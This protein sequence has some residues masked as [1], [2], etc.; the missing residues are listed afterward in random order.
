MPNLLD[1]IRNSKLSWLVF[2]QLRKIWVRVVGFAVFAL[3]TAGLSQLAGPLVPARMVDRLGSDAVD[4]VLSILASS[5][6]AVTTFSLSI[7]VSAFASAAQS[8]TPRATALLQEDRTTQNVL[9]TFLGAFLF[10]LVGIV[11]LKAGYYSDAGRVVLFVA[12]ILTIALVVV[13]LIRWISHLT[14]FGRMHDTLERVEEAASRAIDR[15]LKTPWLGGRPQTAP[16]PETGTPVFAQS[17]NYVQHIDMDA[18]SDAAQDL[19]TDLWVM[20]L[21]GCLVHPKA[22][23]LMADHMALD[24]TEQ[25]RLRNAFTFDQCRNFAQDPAFGLQVISEIASRALSPAVNDPGTANEVI[26][27][28]TRILSVWR[29][30]EAAD[31]VYPNVHVPTLEVDELIDVSFGPIARDGAAIFEVQLQLH[32]ALRTLCKIAPKTFQEPAT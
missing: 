12:T 20:A 29:V 14:N 9:A 27:R 6:L 5:M 16:A 10:S 28:L 2:A 1:R 19:G 7:A 31:V 32:C 13:A 3:A 26:G 18:L 24:E 11:A 30:E 25:S 22:P 17:V 4:Q 21:P 23:L 15:R 8:A